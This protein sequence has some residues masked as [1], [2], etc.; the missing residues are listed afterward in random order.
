[1]GVDGGGAGEGGHTRQQRRDTIPEGVEK[2]R[3]GLPGEGKDFF[4]K[5]NCFYGKCLQLGS[6]AGTDL[7][8]KKMGQRGGHIINIAS[9]AGEKQRK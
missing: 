3:G 2:V 9:A 6:M 1:M 8:F 4:K 5:T 7:A